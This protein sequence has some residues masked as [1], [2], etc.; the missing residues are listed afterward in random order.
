[1]SLGS[2]AT[3]RGCIAITLNILIAA[4]AMGQSGIGNI[5]QGHDIAT[6]ICAECHRV[7][8]GQKSAK[9]SAAK[10]FQDVADNPART[11]LSLRVF[12]KTPHRNM[13][14][15]VLTEAEIDDIIAYIQSL[16]RRAR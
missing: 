5:A 12:L 16:N 2:T 14:N 3:G 11:E 1:M 8:K 6:T 7:E 15:L 9:L 10:S 13:P 4:T